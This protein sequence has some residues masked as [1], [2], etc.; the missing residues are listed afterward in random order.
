MEAQHWLSEACDCRYIDLKQ[1]KELTE[2]LLQ[3]GRMLNSMMEKANLF[4]GSSRH[5]IREETAEYSTDTDL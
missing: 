5:V 4:C 2:E 3:I 1:M